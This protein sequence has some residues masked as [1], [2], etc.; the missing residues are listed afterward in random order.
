MKNKYRDIL[1]LQLLILMILYYKKEINNVSELAKIFGF[2]YVHLYQKI[3]NLEEKKYIFIKKVKK[4]LE[5]KIKQK[6]KKFINNLLR[7]LK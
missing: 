5:I 1:P 6:G 7:E 2:T 3:I 4:T